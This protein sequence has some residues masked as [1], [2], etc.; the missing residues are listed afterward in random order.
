V[1]ALAAILVPAALGAQAGSGS[2]SPR[3][4]VQMRW[5]SMRLV[6]HGRAAGRAWRGRTSAA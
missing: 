6:G 3:F 2:G 4:L 5:K 1:L